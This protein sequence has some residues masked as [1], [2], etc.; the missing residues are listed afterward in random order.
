M[1]SPKSEGSAYVLL[2][3]IVGGVDGQKGVWAYVEGGMGSISECLAKNAKSFGDQIEIYTSQNVKQIELENP[4]GR[5]KVKG[6][7]L[8]NG[9]F[10]ESDVILSNATPQVTFKKLLSKYNLEKHSDDTV[11]KFFKRIDNINYDSG[12]MKINLAVNKIP[13]FLADPN[14]SENHVMPHHQAT[15]HINCENMELLDV[16]FNEANIFKKAS[17]KPMIEYV[18]Y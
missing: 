14:S 18:S 8:S 13:N 16:A 6:V 3:H 12:T 10:I 17:S 11:S 15:I 7:L 1:L 4:N 5:P 2:H 9:R